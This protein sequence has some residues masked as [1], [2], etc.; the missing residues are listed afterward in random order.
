MIRDTKRF[1]FVLK[2]GIWA[3]IVGQWVGVVSVMVSTTQAFVIRAR[4]KLEASSKS[5][6]YHQVHKLQADLTL[7]HHPFVCLLTPDRLPFCKQLVL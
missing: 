3:E 5:L 6:L 1:L 7:A 2:L 4:A